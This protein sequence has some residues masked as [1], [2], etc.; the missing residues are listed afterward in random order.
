M[1]IITILKAISVVG[2]IGMAILALAVPT[3][4]AQADAAECTGMVQPV[5]KKMAPVCDTVGTK[6]SCR[7]DYYYFPSPE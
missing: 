1:K 2:G 4:D 5:C 6:I 3:K 7:T